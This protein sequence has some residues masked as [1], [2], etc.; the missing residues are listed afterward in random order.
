MVNGGQHG[1]VT[2]VL[3]AAGCRFPVV[4]GA[5]QLPVEPLPGPMIKPR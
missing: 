5:N 4:V 2:L 3:R 1:V